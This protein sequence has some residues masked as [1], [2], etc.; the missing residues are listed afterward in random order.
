MSNNKTK[1]ITTQI[2]AIVRGVAV[3]YCLVRAS[4]WSYN[5]SEEFLRIFNG[6]S[7]TG[8]P[9]SHILAVIIQYGQS[10]FIWWA[11]KSYKRYKVITRNITEVAKAQ[12]TA[13]GADKARLQAVEF[14]YREE[15][16]TE[17]WNTIIWA[18]LYVLSLGVDIGTNV[19][20]F[21]LG[22]NGSGSAVLTE[23][24]GYTPAI[25]LIAKVGGSL[26]V[27]MIA[28]VEEMIPGT[29]T[30]TGTAFNDIME[31]LGVKRLWFWD[32]KEIVPKI[33]PSGSDPRGSSAGKVSKKQSS[34]N[35]NK[36]VGY[37]AGNKGYTPPAYTLPTTKDRK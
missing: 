20:Q 11:I 2:L 35:S 33:D 16:T 6:A 29:L 7:D 12:K 5:Q 18:S 32:L 17:Y 23:T 3:T 8:I 34:W 24:V 36:S 21:L 31:T 9:I 4:L 10:L 15:L 25:G 30:A 1:N 28:F 19:G 27:A 26:L 14:K 13:N 37:T 22:F